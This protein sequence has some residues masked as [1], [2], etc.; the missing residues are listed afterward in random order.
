[1]TR[2]FYDPRRLLVP[3]LLL[4]STIPARTAL[5]AD[6]QALYRTMER[7]Y[8]AAQAADWS[9]VRQELYLETILD[10][11]RAYALQ[12]PTDP[13]YGE[14][15]ELTVRVA[16]G[17]HYDPL[18]DHDAAT[19]YVREA[20]VWVERHE[21]DPAL[22]EQ[23][24]ALLARANAETHPQLLAAYADA[25]AE[26]N[27]RRYPADTYAIL[28]TV[29]AP[30]RAWLLTRDPSWRAVAFRRAARPDFPL[31][32][33]PTTWGPGFVD[34]FRSA[35]AGA[36]GFS[37]EERAEAEILARR[38]A[39]LPVPPVVARVHAVPEREA[40]T[41]LAPADEY[42]GKM[43]MSILGIENELRR[44]AYFEHLGYADRE[45]DTAVL[46]ANAIDAMHRAYPR[47]RALP[48]LLYECYRELSVMSTLQARSAAERMRAILTVEYP[49]SPQARAVLA[50]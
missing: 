6:P 10:A 7:A 50:S 1:M 15:A 9:F 12:R 27:A 3:F 43:Q 41:L 21:D 20:C 44:I 28:Q 39:A 5:L 19:W 16:S 29:E 4:W 24:R 26:A 37:A 8:A 32:H 46:T 30:W 2:A 35:A 49:D 17:L 48:R 25:D 42:F 40:L 33:L 23:A 36:A 38:H 14:L 18:L 22:K 47:D 34:A 13:V 11:G 45:S 31:A